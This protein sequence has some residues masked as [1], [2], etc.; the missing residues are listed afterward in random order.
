MNSE[1]IRLEKIGKNRWLIPKK[2]KMRVDGLVYA[3][4]E[5][6][7]HIRQDNALQQ[8]M[9]VACLPG[10]LKYSIAMPDIH[11]G[12]GFPIGGIAGMKLPDGVISPGGIG[13]DINCSVRLLRT[14]LTIKDIKDK[15]SLLT[16]NLFNNIPSGVG[17]SGKIKLSSEKVKEILEKGARWAVENGF[18]EK[19]DLEYIEE[20]GCLTFANSDVVSERAIERGRDQ[21]GTL[22]AG[23][24]FLEIEIVEQ[25]YNEKVAKIFGIFPGQITILFHTG[26][27][28]L[29]YQICDDYIKVM[30]RAVQ[31][32]GISLADMQLV[33]AP[34]K[35]S[36]GQDYFRAMCAAANYAWTNR[37]CITHLIRESFEEVLQRSSQDIQLELVYDGAHNIGKVE[38]HQVNG[39]EEEIFVHRKGATRAFPAGHLAIPKK[40]QEVGQP[41]LVPGTMGTYSYVLIGTQTAME[42][43]WG[44]ICHGSGRMMS[45]GEAVR[46]GD[47]DNLLTAMKKQGILVMAKGKKSLLE[48]APQAYKDVEMVVETCEE[49]GIS[50]K[51]ARLKP[52]AVIKG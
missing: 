47:L 7:P 15:L 19:Q 20:K 2:D 52:I 22:G 40:Y 37:E 41:V 23:N 51:V 1:E 31:K 32:Y 45:R 27:R 38:K 43:T 25:V 30:R 42:E 6:L 18:G 48:E 8:V 28:G 5:M 14:N 29:G 11:W 24:H 46:R 13:Y 16:A 12:Y 17:G 21:L 4:E 33:C 34:F 44:S 9:N 3:C 39:K 36:E 49:A 35:S 10:I 50:K 26:S